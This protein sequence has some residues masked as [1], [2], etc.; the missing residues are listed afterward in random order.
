MS[1]TRRG[2]HFYWLRCDACLECVELVRWNPGARASC[3]LIAEGLAADRVKSEGWRTNVE[4]T[5]HVCPYCVMLA[6]TER[7]DAKRRVELPEP[8]VS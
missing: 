5:H 3:K 8:A 6:E 1:I 7:R 4:V 2:G